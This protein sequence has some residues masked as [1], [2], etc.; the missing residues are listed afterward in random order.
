MKQKYVMPTIEYVGTFL[1][2]AI[3]AGSTKPGSG[4]S[5]GQGEGGGTTDVGGQEGEDGPPETSSKE[6][7]FNAWESWDEY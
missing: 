6:H 5:S 7:N 3:L 4:A 2:T 1:E